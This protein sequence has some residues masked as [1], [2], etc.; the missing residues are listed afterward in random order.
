MK[1]TLYII[2]LG[3]LWSL[4]FTR[5]NVNSMNVA[6]A[7][8]SAISGSLVTFTV[9]G[10]N[11]TGD[12]YLKYVLPTSAAYDIVFQNATQI[13]TVLT[14]PINIASLGLWIEHDPIFL[15]PANSNFSVT[16]TA[17]VLTNIRT[18]PT[19]DTTAIFAPD[20]QI[21][22]IL[23][24]AIAK[25]TPIADV[26]ITNTLSS[27]NPSFSGDNISYTIILQN[28]WSTDAT[29]IT[30]ISNFP[31]PTL[32]AP[33]ATFNGSPYAYNFINY[34]QDFVWSGSYLSILNPGQTMAIAMDAIMTHAYPV[35][36]TFNHTAK[37]TSAS[38]E[39]TTGNNSSLATWI[40]QSSADVWI[41]KT[42]VPFTGFNI[43]DKV[44]Y[45]IAYGNSWGKIASGVVLS[46]IAPANINIPVTSL[47]L[48][49]LPAGSGGTF[50]LT[51][52]LTSL[53]ASWYTFVNTANISTTS[54]ESSTGNN[55]STATGIIQWIANVT[56]DIIANNLTR[57]QLDNA[58]Y[59]S[60]PNILIQAVSGDLVQ[61]TITYANF[62][63]VTG[64]N[65]IIWLSWT[66]GF[67]SL[68]AYNGNIGTLQLNMTGV[69]IITWIVGPQ[70]YI[71]FT[72]TARLNYNSWQLL[73]DSVIIQEPFVCGD[74]L[75]TR[76]EPCDTLWNLWI[77]YSGQ[78][79][80]NQQGICVL[81]T[82]SIINNACVNWQYTTQL[83]AM[84]T[85]QACS[86]VTVPLMNA[87]CNSM[88]WSA[89]ITN[90]TSWYTTNLTC[91][92]A[93]AT[94]T[95][96]ITI[97]CG[98]GTTL[99]WF[100]TSFNGTCTY[101]WS[102]VG[103]AQCKVGSD[104]TNAACRVPVSVNAGQCWALDALDGTIAI[105]NDGRADSTFR[106]ETLNHTTAQTITIDCGNGTQ[107][108]TN[109]ASVFEAWCEY[110][111]VTTPQTYPV[112]CL[113]DGVS[114]PTCQEN[115]IVDRANLWYCGNNI[116]EGYE[117][118]DGTDTPEGETCDE[119]CDIQWSST[120][121]WC[122]NVGNT[123]LSIQKWEVLPFRWTLDDTDNI[124]PGN[125]CDGKPDGKIPEDSIM[126]TFD[127]YNGDH[128]E[129]DNNPVYTFTQ[130]CKKDN[131]NALPIF[132]YLQTI[133]ADRWS[134][135][136]AFGK[137]AIDSHDFMTSSNTIFG[138]YKISLDKVKYQYCRSDDKSEWTEIDRV[139]SVN[140]TVTKPYLAQ[141]S[142]F[143]ITP[144]SANIKL[145]GYKMLDGTDLVNSTDLADIMVLNESVYNATNKVDTLINTFITKYSK[146]AITVDDQ[147]LPTSLKGL[148][149]TVKVVPNQKIYILQSDTQKTITMK[150]ITSFTAPFTIVTKNID[151]V[152]KG[153]VTYNGM[154]LV[155]NG[156]ITFEKS[157]EKVHEDR[158]PS[159]QTVKWIFIT[160]KWFLGG[161]DLANTD[162]SKLRC[163]Y[164]WL[165]VKG[166]LIGNN[167]DAIVQ[168]KRSQLN[169]WFLTKSSTPAA[170]K[171]ERRNEIFNG[172]SVLIEYSPS[173]RSA[174]P[175]GASEFTKALDVY[176]Q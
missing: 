32:F 168:A 55:S 160:D 45:I 59:G 53:L 67:T 112:E 143:G 57:P 68:W 12:T 118:C 39:Y 154:F 29:G 87:T 119:Y 36:T 2:V 5:A 138:E 117:Q 60:G 95:T 96:P 133:W 76:N 80:E 129:S 169:D 156:T 113:V 150:D 148:G 11:G 54:I 124:I 42:L 70:N 10:T 93:N 21:S 84:V 73:T 50:I 9:T 56:L 16:I 35:G 94:A 41:T 171:A 162:T 44:Q 109:N 126:C 151:I 85:G 104:V 79:C 137:Y 19:L 71:S 123:N 142:S 52:T 83:G 63:N 163:T 62:G 100:G 105:I 166:I 114:A 75:L 140:F 152:I 127:I 23:T 18:L 66:Q 115:L 92:T 91:K 121:V 6:P 61:L 46:D 146:L 78:V 65:A 134:L 20:M 8:Q 24:S 110:A 176:K 72:P 13:P 58:P 128:K 145:D 82:T 106:C 157:D 175:P 40:V 88:T 81:R 30:F 25:I 122:F 89:P 135:Q 158:C 49:T 172:A 97:D 170:I 132:T 164:G 17:K 33:T 90:N 103:N 101:A 64:M 153:D 120:M 139:C 102:F 99:T 116:R 144:K 130:P 34:P 22:T 136:H 74:G 1:K 108:T 111:N 161:D 159:T 155:K 14:T 31:I 48:G 47:M 147:Y 3:L 28:I 37:V 165:Y 51:W 69:L 43:G 141:K 125:I 98:N 173:L 4:G 107:H 27:A 7:T 77:L 86:S 15:I 149:I 26:F 38:P 174:L 167:I 131:R